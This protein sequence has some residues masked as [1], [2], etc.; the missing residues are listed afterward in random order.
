MYKSAS[1][2]Q[3]LNARHRVPAS[4][5]VV[6]H[7]VPVT[8]FRFRFPVPISVSDASSAP[9]AV[10]VRCIAAG[11]KEPADSVLMPGPEL[12]DGKL[13]A[14]ERAKASKW[15]SHQAQSIVRKATLILMVSAERTLSDSCYPPPPQ[16]PFSYF[17]IFFPSSKLFACSCCFLV[18]KDFFFFAHFLHLFLFNLPE[19]H[20][21]YESPRDVGYL[22]SCQWSMT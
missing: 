14:E 7:R 18:F 5:A 2:L 9:A 8:D 22:L 21:I 19:V 15:V 12:V 6:A 13:G 4:L 3:L 1:E 10:T 17:F 20:S 16:C 11:L